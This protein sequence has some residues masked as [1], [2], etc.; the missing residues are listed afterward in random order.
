MAEEVTGGAGGVSNSQHA[1][2]LNMSAFRKTHEASIILSLEK[3]QRNISAVSDKTNSPEC[4]S[5]LRAH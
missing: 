2:E 4:I 3:T 1:V 5:A